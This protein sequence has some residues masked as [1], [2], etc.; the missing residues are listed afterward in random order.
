MTLPPATISSVP[1]ADFAEANEELANMSTEQYFTCCGK[2]ICGGCLLSFCE[3]GNIENCPFCKADHV[4]KTDEE[5]V[6]ELMKQVEVNDAGAIHVLGSKYYH[7]QLN[8]QQDRA[9]AMELW[10]QAAALGSS[11]AHYHLGLYYREGGKL[12]KAKFHFEA[13]AIAGHEGAR[14]ALGLMEAQSGNMEQAVKH[15]AIAASAGNY[16][17]MNALLLAF[18][19][20]F[21]SRDAIDS[22]LTAY[23]NSCVEMRSEARDAAIRIHIASIGA[24]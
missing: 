22:T 21:F 15:W 4:H 20:G 19:Q 13:A 16:H 2:Y 6:D 18:K 9:R 17:A 1:I 5:R 3:F 8:L 23:N 7:G 24:R 14:M 11:M 12:K 10:T